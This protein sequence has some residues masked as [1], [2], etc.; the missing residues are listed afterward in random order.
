[1][2]CGR[3]KPERRACTTARRVP[4]MMDWSW[5]SIQKWGGQSTMSVMM[6]TNG[7]LG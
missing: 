5:S 3:K 4:Q 6:V 2:F 1:M 7:V